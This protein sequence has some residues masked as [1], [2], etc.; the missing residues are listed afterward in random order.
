MRR[1]MTYDVRTLWQLWKFK[2][3]PTVKRQERHGHCE[4]ILPILH[5]CSEEKYP[6]LIE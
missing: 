3:P 4:E 6:F 2:V 1:I 5:L